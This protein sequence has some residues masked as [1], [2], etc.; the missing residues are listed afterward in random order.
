MWT[1]LRIKSLEA[2]QDAGEIRLAPQTNKAKKLS[3]AEARQLLSGPVVVEE[4]VDEAGSLRAFVYE[5]N[6]GTKSAPSPYQ[7]QVLELADV[8]RALAELMAP[9]GETE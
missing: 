2:W 7:V 9:S 4:K 3:V 8:P 5:S 1:K 6:V